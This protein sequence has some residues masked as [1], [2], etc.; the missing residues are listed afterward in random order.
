MLIFLKLPYLKLII[1][2]KT[3][4]KSDH[5][6]ILVLLSVWVSCGNLSISFLTFKT[7]LYRLPQLS[8]SEHQPPTRQ[9]TKVNSCLSVFRRKGIKIF[10]E[11]LQQRGLKKILAARVV[12]KSQLEAAEEV[13]G[14]T[15][16]P[17]LL[18]RA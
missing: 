18:S 1:A 15:Q 4:K 11:P 12:S 16:R 7:I 3:K 2:R 9:Q 17:K 6:E 10:S 8:D 13:A 14:V 5:P